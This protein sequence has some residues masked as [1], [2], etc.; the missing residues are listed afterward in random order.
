MEIV[1]NLLFAILIALVLYLVFLRVRSNLLKQWK[2][3]SVKEV[4]FY[5][6]L[7]ELAKHFYNERFNLKN[8]DNAQIFRLI[9]RYK[10]KK[11][12]H[13]LLKERQELFTSL[14][15]LLIEVEDLNDDKYTSLIEQFKELQ[16]ARRV[17]N[18]KVLIYNQTISTW[19][20]KF[21]ATKLNLKQKE[22]F[23]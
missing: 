22:Y 11:I 16:R 15:H 10:K 19:P 12:R 5:K 6:L 8:E 13:L 18:S 23:G 9:S 3:V 14:N 21:I 7:L 17:Y 20:T 1:F 2:E 4:I